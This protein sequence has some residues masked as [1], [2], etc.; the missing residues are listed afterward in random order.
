[1]SKIL[2]DSL[3]ILARLEGYGIYYIEENGGTEKVVKFA[4]L[5]WGT[6]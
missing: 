4:Q 6:I 5:P 2:P 1:M 3:S